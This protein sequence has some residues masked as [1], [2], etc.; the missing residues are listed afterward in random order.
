MRALHGT[1]RDITLLIACDCLRA[2]H[3][4]SARCSHAGCRSLRVAPMLVSSLQPLKRRHTLCFLSVIALN[5]SFHSP[6]SSSDARVCRTTARLFSTPD[7]TTPSALLSTACFCSSP[8]SRAQQ[9]KQR[10]SAA[11]TIVH[12]DMLL[13]CWSRC[14]CHAMPW[15]VC[16]LCCNK[17]RVRSAHHCSQQCNTG[18][19]NDEVQFGHSFWTIHYFTTHC[20]AQVHCES[21]T[22]H[23]MA[24]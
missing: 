20:R 21:S 11:K 22:L 15:D 19:V 23:S 7:T 2:H 8:S 9:P 12:R 3:V 13:Q 10:A 16:V 24:A 4:T 18:L 1:T 6:L 17:P 14:C 5:P